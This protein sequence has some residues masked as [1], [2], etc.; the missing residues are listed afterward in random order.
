MGLCLALL[1]CGCAPGPIPIDS[2][3]S[4]LIT[5]KCQKYARCGVIARSEIPQ[6]VAD[7]QLLLTYPPALPAAAEVAAG[8][9][10]YDG[11]ATRAC[12]DAWLSS[13]CAD[14]LDPTSPSACPSAFTAK[15]ALGGAC[16]DT[17]ECAVGQCAAGGVGCTG[18]CRPPL[19]T[20]AACATS[21]ECGASGFCDGTSRHCA[22]RS[23]T[24]GRCDASQ[25]CP[26][27]EVCEGGDAH[28]GSGACQTPGGS[29]ASCHGQY[30][31]GEDCAPGLFCDLAASP[32]SCRSRVALGAVCAAASD[33]TTGLSCVKRAGAATGTCTAWLDLD[34]ACDP[35]LSGSG[36]GACPN[37]AFCDT[38]AK[39]CTAF[40]VGKPGI[41]CHDHSACGIGLF[42]PF[43]LYYCNLGNHCSPVIAAGKP[44]TPPAPFADEPCFAS[45]CDPVGM[46]C[47]VVCK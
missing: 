7:G 28:G 25:R 18:T 17:L 41:A 44:C 27:G 21:V 32:P 12:I 24:G 46:T 4:E 9:L 22:L 11:A 38:I 23:M 35:T 13:N 37:D 6:C 30:A 47:V 26:I 31:V 16:R 14:D 43:A 36:A 19:A 20:G 8:R 3:P 1:A 42:E 33:C 2:Y 40:G 5:A 10:G 34:A 15:V 45:V 29:G 39:V